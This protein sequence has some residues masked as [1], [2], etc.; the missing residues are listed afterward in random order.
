MEPNI[1]ANE[2]ALDILHNARQQ[3]IALGLKC[4]VVPMPHVGAGSSL[5]LHVA[6]TDADVVRS[7]CLAE[8]GEHWAESGEGRERLAGIVRFHEQSTRTLD[9]GERFIVQA[10]QGFAPPRT[11]SAD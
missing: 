10:R 8:L 1:V 11:P 3:L 4:V 7:H 6:Y 5:T 2:A 9:A